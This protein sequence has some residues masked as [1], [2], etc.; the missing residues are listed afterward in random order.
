[1]SDNRHAADDEIMR[2]LGRLGSA[3]GD[4]ARARR[5]R[6]RCHRELRRRSQRARVPSAAV[7]AGLGLLGLVYL[8]QITRLA[9]LMLRAG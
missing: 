8:A 6:A 4:S 9:I 1:M 5:T 3:S 2:L 7:D